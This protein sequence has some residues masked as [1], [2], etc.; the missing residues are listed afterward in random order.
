MARLYAVFPDATTLETATFKLGLRTN[1]R[2]IARDWFSKEEKANRPLLPVSNPDEMDQFAAGLE[3][4]EGKMLEDALGAGSPVLVV[5][6]P[7]EDLARQ[8]EEAGA[9]RVFSR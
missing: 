7:E 3:G 6:E 5:D 2:V 9:S 4:E 8:L 1:V